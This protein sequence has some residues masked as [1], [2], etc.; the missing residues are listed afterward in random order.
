MNA[1]TLDLAYARLGVELP[2][3]KRP[4]CATAQDGSLVLVCQSA[5]FSRPSAGVLRYSAA[6]SRITAPRVHIGALRTSL[7][8]ASAAGTPIR[9][10]V[11]TLKFDGRS[12]RVHS[13]ADLVGSI[14]AFDGDAYSVD[15]V[16]IAAE[17]A[18]SSPQSLPKRR[19][20]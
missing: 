18:E 12:N 11:Q 15:F 6:L 20:R 10:I 2:Q 1:V 17:E 4:L 16:R 3:R 19:K 14:Q 5:G 9:L 13:R 7:E 8:A